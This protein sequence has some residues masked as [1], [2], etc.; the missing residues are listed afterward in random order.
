M[1]QQRIQLPT[2]QRLIQRFQHFRKAKVKTETEPVIQ[3]EPAPVAPSQTPPEN[4]PASLR[5]LVRTA[6]A[7]AEQIAAGITQEAQTKAEAEASKIVAQANS[8]AREIVVKAEM[9]ARR[10][11]ERI[12]SEAAKK[13]KLTEVETKQKALHFL[14]TASQEIEKEIKQEYEEAFSRL[15]AHVQAMIKEGQNIEEEFKNRID[16]LWENKSL[17]LKEYSTALLNS[18]SEEVVPSPETSP[19][20]GNGVEDAPLDQERIEEPIEPRKEVI[21]KKTVV[22]PPSAKAAANVVIE[23]SKPLQEPIIMEEQAENTDQKKEPPLPVTQPPQK[24]AIPAEVVETTAEELPSEQE[25]AAELEASLSS[26]DGEALYNSEVELVIPPVALE[27]VSSFYNY[28]QTIPE[29]RILYTRG[30]WDQGTT[31]A[32]VPEKP[33]PLIGIITKASKVVAIPQPTDKDVQL[34]GKA[35]ALKGDTKRTTKMRVLL[36][37]PSR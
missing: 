22:P 8:E 36:R 23:Q 33:M 5:P 15:S 10:E 21:E 11:A 37:A 17:E 9:D 24:A 13:A 12:L 3:E 26:M 16:R 29:L 31:I 19:P 2:F 34:A 4:F 25:S 27:L 30:S 35:G 32:I 7:D 20:A 18:G 28:L 6:I 1:L 14:I